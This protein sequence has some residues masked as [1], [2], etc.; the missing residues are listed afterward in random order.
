MEHWYFANKT[1]CPYTT[2]L[3]HLLKSEDLVELCTYSPIDLFHLIWLYSLTNMCGWQW[4][5]C[6]W[7]FSNRVPVIIM[8][9]NVEG[10]ILCLAFCT[11][12]LHNTFDDFSKCFSHLN[13]FSLY[14]LCNEVPKYSIYTWTGSTQIRYLCFRISRSSLCIF[15]LEELS[16]KI[17]NCIESHFS[18]FISSAYIWDVCTMYPKYLNVRSF[19]WQYFGG[20]SRSC[21]RKGLGSFPCI[22][23]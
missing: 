5:L 11:P 23:L 18:N 22:S 20:F 8:Y 19:I 10:S 6:H 1:V 13:L 12:H 2:I 9:W 14:F 16:N 21:I 17:H 3:F 7:T 4:V 15:A